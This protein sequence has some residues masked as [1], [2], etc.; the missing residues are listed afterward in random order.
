MDA[1]DTVDASISWKIDDHLEV[2]LEAI[3][4]TNETSNEWV[5]TSAWKLPLTYTQTGRE[6]L[7]GL[8]YRF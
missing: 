3:N 8:R 7:L 1:V 2:S 6:F 5:G 4:L